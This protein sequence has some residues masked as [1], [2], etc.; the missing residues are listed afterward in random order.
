MGTLGYGRAIL[1]VTRRESVL[2]HVGGVGGSPV[3][4]GVRIGWG[5]TWYNQSVLLHVG[6]V[7]GMVVVGL[8]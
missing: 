8:L 4:G 2:L 3:W 1:F 6:V 7:G 5:F